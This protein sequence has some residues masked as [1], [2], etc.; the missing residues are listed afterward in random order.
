MEYGYE[1]L[2]FD[3]IKVPTFTF[4]GGNIRVTSGW[5]DGDNLDGVLF[6]MAPENTEVGAVINPE[7]EG[8]K[9]TDLPDIKCYMRFDKVES[10]DVVIAKLNELKVKLIAK[11]DA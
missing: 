4:G 3:G 5:E 7:L 1:I 2:N 8:K 6:S 11:Q 10:I 9:F